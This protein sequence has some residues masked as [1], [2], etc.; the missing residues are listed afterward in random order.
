MDQ[1]FKAPVAPVDSIL[2]VGW[3][4]WA[5]LPDILHK[6]VRAKMDTGARTSAL[7]ATH[8][9]LR[10]DQVYFRAVGQGH[11]SHAP[12]HDER[13]VTDAGGHR[14]LRPVILTTLEVGGYRAAVE[15]SLTGRRGLRYRLLVGRSSMAGH[16]CVD[17]Q[18]SYLLSDS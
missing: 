14:E 12:L 2:R 9:R 17:P 7:A 4:E 8:I 1:D 11:E 10:D 6:P 13:W 15:V 16:F 18:A 3:R 5:R